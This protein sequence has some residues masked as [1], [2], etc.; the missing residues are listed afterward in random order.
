M[1]RKF[2]VAVF[3][4]LVAS[5]LA[6][7]SASANWSGVTGQL[8]DG[9]TGQNWTRGGTVYVYDCGN[10]I[11]PL[12]SADADATGAF[13]VTITPPS[14]S[15]DRYLCIKATFNAVDGFPKSAD[16]L[17]AIEDPATSSGIRSADRPFYTNT[18]PNVIAL[19][20]MSATTALTPW[21]LILAALLVAAA[22]LALGLVLRRR[23]AKV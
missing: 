19:R 20:D 6:S 3:I 7:T 22:I 12:N 18:G 15:A 5:L 17:Q 14:P 9:K 8:V 16:Y 21:P 10:F 11:T 4:V 13:T 2:A 23:T 1:N